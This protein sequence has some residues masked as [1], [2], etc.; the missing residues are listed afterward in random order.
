VNEISGAPLQVLVVEDNPGDV[1]LLREA[2]RELNARLDLRVARDGAEAIRVLFEEEH[3][4]RPDLIFLDLDLPKISGR[5][6]LGRLKADPAT[7]KIPVIVLTWS[8]TESD[9]RQAYES[10]ANAYIR[11][12]RTLEELVH[13]IRGFKTFWMDTARLPRTG[14]GF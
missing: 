9:V 4:W 1:R 3:S 10:H 6:V 14:I 13:C 2:F 8:R 12:P 11:K 5:D 7:K